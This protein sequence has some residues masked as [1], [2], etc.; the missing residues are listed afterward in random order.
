MQIS[1]ALAGI[2]E[3]LAQ[4]Q[5]GSH[6]E[7]WGGGVKAAKLVFVAQFELLTWRAVSN[8]VVLESSVDSGF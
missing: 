4:P 8:R 5:D 7:E 6:K 2:Q 3:K 1:S